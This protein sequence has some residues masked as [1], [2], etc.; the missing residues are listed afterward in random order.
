MNRRA[1]QVAL[2]GSKPDVCG[3]M[4]VYARSAQ[5]ALVG[6][7]ETFHACDVFTTRDAEGDGWSLRRTRKAT[8]PPAI[9]LK[10]G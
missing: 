6:A 8:F 4:L 1:F 2:I 7:A 3:T 5:A 9:Q 10:Q